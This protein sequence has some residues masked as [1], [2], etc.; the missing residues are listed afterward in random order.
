MERAQLQQWMA[1]PS[2]NNSNRTTPLI[3][4][5]LLTGPEMGQL[6]FLVINLNFQINNFN[7]FIK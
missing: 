6:N 7:N 5:S 2:Q 4:I 3:Y 1:Q